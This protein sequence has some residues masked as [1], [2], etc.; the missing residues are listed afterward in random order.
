MRGGGPGFGVARCCA[1]ALLGVPLAGCAGPLSS[2][3]P[4]GRSAALVADLWWVM[5]AGAAV[6]FVATMAVVLVSVARP[7]IDAAVP[8][9]VWLVGGGLVLPAAVLT[10]L[11]VYALWAGEQLLAHPGAATVVRIDV[12]ARQWQWDVAYPGV[13]GE[14]VVTTGVVHVPVDR[15]VDVHVTSADVIHSFW[16]P[17]LAGKIDAIPGHVNV[18]RLTATSAGTY[19]G[20]C[21]EFCGT[22]HAHMP[23]VVQAHPPE[24]YADA[25]R[26]AVRAAPAGTAP[27]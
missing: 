18:V 27:R 7:G 15:P 11:L 5:M 8:W 10:P 20:Q 12:T 25:L 1:L 21:A 17:R 4:A 6:L 26:G 14:P 16:V 3:D 2:I 24:S 9:T 22:G 19:R 13:E 23:F